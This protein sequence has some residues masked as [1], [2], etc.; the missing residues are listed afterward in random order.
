MAGRKAVI[1]IVGTIIGLTIG[2]LITT[3]PDRSEE[4]NVDRDSLIFNGQSVGIGSIPNVYTITLLYE[5]RG[6]TEDSNYCEFLVTKNAGLEKIE[7]TKKLKEQTYGTD[8][9]GRFSFCCNMSEGAVDWDSKLKQKGNGI[10]VGSKFKVISVNSD[11]TGKINIFDWNNIDKSLR[12]WENSEIQ[13]LSYLES[14]SGKIEDGTEVYIT[15]SSIQLISKSVIDIEHISI[16]LSYDDGSKEELMIKGKSDC[17]INYNSDHDIKGKKY[18]YKWEV[19]KEWNVK[20]IAEVN[21]D[22]DI[23]IIEK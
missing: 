1:I 17:L 21:V 19:E 22:D 6:N 14:V 8:F 5:S 18:Y 9:M 7:L 20:D 10:I 15:P 16:E 4:F 11:F 3:G 23:F 13:M 2:Y 12:R